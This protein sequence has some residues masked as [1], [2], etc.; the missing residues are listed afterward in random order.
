M[1]DPLLNFAIFI[2]WWWMALLA[3]LPI[4][5]KRVEEGDIALGH[6]SGAPQQAQIVK[7]AVWAAGVALILWALTAIFIWI[8]PFHIR[9]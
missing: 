1:L 5:V 7:K 6:D 4:G 9:D 8:D 3:L 2:I